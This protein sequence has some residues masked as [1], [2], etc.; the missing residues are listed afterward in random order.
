MR[1]WRMAA[2]MVGCALCAVAA[3]A[4]RA[5]RDVLTQPEIEKI[6][7]AGIEPSLRINL[8]GDFVKERVEKVVALSKRIPSVARDRKIDGAL[9]D[10]SSLID[11]LGSNLD[12]YGDRKADLRPA[13]KGLAKDSSEWLAELKAIPPAASYRLSLEDATDAEKDLVDQSMEMLKEQTTYFKLHKDQKG[14]ERAE[15][16]Y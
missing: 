16:E 10:L 4:Q 12:Q 6:R 5:H 1:G 13:L 8:Y 3:T 2:A 15:P 11:E 7:E 9:Q 14:Q